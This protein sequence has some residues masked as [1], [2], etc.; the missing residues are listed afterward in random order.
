MLKYKPSAKAGTDRIFLSSDSNLV[1]SQ[2]AE[3]QSKFRRNIS[4]PSAAKLDNYF[5]LVF[6]LDLFFVP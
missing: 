4:H 1:Y 6:S 5:M 2:S 3:N